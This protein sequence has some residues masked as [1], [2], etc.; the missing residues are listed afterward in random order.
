MAETRPD[1]ENEAA[2]EG[3]VE[4]AEEIHTPVLQEASA[5]V[6]EDFP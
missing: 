3:S 2:A 1:P 6:P 4:K 5:A